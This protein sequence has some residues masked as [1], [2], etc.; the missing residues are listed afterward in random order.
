MSYRIIPYYTS[1]KV[2]KEKKFLWWTYWSTAQQYSMYGH[3]RSA[4][5][6]TKDK[7]RE[8]IDKEIDLQKRISMNEAQGVEYY[9]RRWRP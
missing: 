5:F 2:Q 7:A 1:F 3:H 9:P 6:D 8:Y 4:G